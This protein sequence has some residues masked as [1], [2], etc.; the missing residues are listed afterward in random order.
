MPAMAD[1]AE[2]E[3]LLARY[4]QSVETGEVDA[5]QLLDRLCGEHPAEAE[6]L[7]RGVTTLI[8]EGLLRDPGDAPTDQPERV[9]G[10]RISRRLGS[11]AMGVVYLAHDEATGEPVSLKL[12]RRSELGTA[13]RARFEREVAIAQKLD[14]PGIAALRLAGVDDT[15]PYCAFDYVPGVSLE[16][17][18]QRLAARRPEQLAAADLAVEPR[19]PATAGDGASWCRRTAEL[20]AEVADALEHAH[21]RG[22]LHRDVKPSNIMLRDDGRSVLVDF[23]LGALEGAQTLTRSGMQLGSIPYMAPEQALGS[24]AN[25]DARSDV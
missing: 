5:R 12:I 25:V 4:L 8:A 18:V 1:H 6:A 23:G 19:P 20:V 7:R 13:G 24:R 15:R 11:G 10:M 17:L 21:A 2:V 9:A 16:D 22:V 14:H 3:T